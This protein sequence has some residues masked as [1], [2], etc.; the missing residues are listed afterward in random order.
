MT[1]KKILKDTY[2]EE[3]QLLKEMLKNVSPRTKNG[4]LQPASAT[5]LFAFKGKPEAILKK[6][7]NIDDIW[8]LKSEEGTDYT[9][10]MLKIDDILQLLNDLYMAA[11]PL[12]NATLS[13]AI[14]K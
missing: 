12:L 2:A 8:G 7:L 1:T 10:L 4:Y 5:F 6:H 14:E 3:V 13:T 9:G 11:I